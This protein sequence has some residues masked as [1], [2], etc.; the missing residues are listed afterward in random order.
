MAHSDWPSPTLYTV[1]P[2]ESKKFDFPIPVVH[3]HDTPTTYFTFLPP[4]PTF[5]HAKP[6][7]S[8]K[9]QNFDSTNIYTRLKRI[10]N[11]EDWWKKFFH[12]SNSQNATPKNV[13]IIFRP[14][15][16]IFPQKLK[17][18]KN[19]AEYPQNIIPGF[20]HD[21]ANFWWPPQNDPILAAKILP[22]KMT[23]FRPQKLY[24]LKWPHLDRRK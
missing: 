18:R 24:P 17:V 23:L 5:N 22:P 19:T 20:G 2:V 13:K 3:H 11:P 1:S 16:V 12:F 9:W 8:Q 14:N 6:N 10:K 7:F 15:G 4:S 21:F